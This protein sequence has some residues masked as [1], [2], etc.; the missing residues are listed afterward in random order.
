MVPIL[1]GGGEEICLFLR[2]FT[3]ENKAEITFCY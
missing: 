3:G 1:F 2:G